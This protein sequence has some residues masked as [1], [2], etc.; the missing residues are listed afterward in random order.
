VPL[1]VGVSPTSHAY[2]ALSKIIK[3]H[4]RGWISLILS[5]NSIVDLRAVGETP[6]EGALTINAALTGQP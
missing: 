5:S 2:V 1:L 4:P 3:I 6:T